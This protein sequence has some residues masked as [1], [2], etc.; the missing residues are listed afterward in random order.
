M[1]DQCDGKVLQDLASRSRQDYALPSRLIPLAFVAPLFMT[2]R[3]SAR[4]DDLGLKPQRKLLM[5]GSCSSNAFFPATPCAAEFGFRRKSGT[6]SIEKAPP[7]SPP[8]KFS[9]ASENT[10]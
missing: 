4:P 1:L 5:N 8:D 7:D 9:V 6:R 10:T 2:E 3:E